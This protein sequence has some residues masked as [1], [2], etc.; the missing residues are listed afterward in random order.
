MAMQTVVTLGGREYTLRQKSKGGTRVW[1]E[2]LR[3]T[4]SVQIFSVLDDVV[5][6]IKD[7]A[8]QIE[9]GGLANADYTQMF[10]VAGII[11]AVY[12]GLTNAPDE[13]WALLYEYS[14]EIAADDEYLDEHA[15]DDEAAHVFVEVLKHN[16]PFLEIWAAVSGR[17]A[18]GTTP[19]S[20]PVNGVSGLSPTGPKKK[21]RTS[22]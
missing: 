8:A 13:I 19:N 15:Y 12:H 17:K 4:L 22:S 11:P 18:P 6:A 7:V 3:Q 16:Y 21:S 1:R 14:P 2:K 9:T 20:P 5:K 10:N